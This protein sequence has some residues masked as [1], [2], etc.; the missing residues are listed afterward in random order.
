MNE[1]S[2]IN[3]QIEK[4]GTAFTTSMITD[5]ESFYDSRAEIYD[6]Q[7]EAPQ[8]QKRRKTI[9]GLYNKILKKYFKK[10]RIVYLDF[11]CGTGTATAEF[12][13]GLNQTLKEG[14]AIDI[15][16]EMIKIAKTALP[17]FNHIKGGVS[18]INWKNKFDLIT[19]FFH[20]LCHLSGVELNKFF[21]S[22]Y[23]GLKRDGF[24]CFDVIKQFDVG[25]HGYTKKDKQENR[26]YIAYHS[27]KRDG[28]TIVDS[29]GD[30]IIGTDRMYSKKDMLDFAEKH[31]F[32]IV[33]IKEVKIEN[34]DPKIGYLNEFVVVLQK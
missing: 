4:Y 19:A 18:K 20:V 12:L 14:Y 24:V 13:A 5:Q 11:G 34:P 9:F 30:P 3:A 1:I 17:K 6:E 10:N 21:K 22:T 16:S 23:Y 28:S 8:R 2:R 31:H 32:K 27:L 33:A 26:K 25:E 15:S 7:N 29:K